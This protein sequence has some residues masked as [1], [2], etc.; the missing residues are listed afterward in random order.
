MRSFAPTLLTTAIAALGLLA[1]PVQAQK[2]PGTPDSTAISGGTYSVDPDHTLVRFEVDHFGITPYTGVFGDVT[3]TL[4]L[5]PA[6]PDTASLDITIPVAKVTTASP[7]LTSHLLRAGK[8]GGLPDFFG[9]A[10][11]PARFVSTSV[12]TTAQGATITGNLTLNGVT[13]PVTLHARLYGAGTMPER[14]GGK[15]NIGFRA[16]AT[17]RRSA[18]GISYGVPMVSD[19]VMLDIIAAFTK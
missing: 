5:N 10:P 16:T 17:I 14:M 18:F 3:G 12:S 15:E 8:D 1:A 9:P 7:G 4:T 6:T 13:R 2:L 19:D 11:Q